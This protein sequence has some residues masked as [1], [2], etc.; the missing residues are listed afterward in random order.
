[1]NLTSINRKCIKVCWIFPK[2]PCILVGTRH[3][4]STEIENDFCSK[5]VILSLRNILSCLVSRQ[6][7]TKLVLSHQLPYNSKPWGKGGTEDTSIILRPTQHNLKQYSNDLAKC[8][9]FASGGSSG[10]FAVYINA[11]HS[12]KKAG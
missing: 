9:H 1:M 6:V 12:E 4:I 3:T 7:F 10:R 11:A 5:W 8:R 2:V